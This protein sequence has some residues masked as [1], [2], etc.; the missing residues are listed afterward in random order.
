MKNSH[1]TGRDLRHSQEGRPSASIGC[2]GVKA[3]GGDSNKHSNTRQGKPAMGK[4]KQKEKQRVK[5]K[6]C[7]D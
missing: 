5:L 3:H 1:Q 2:G 4:K 6:R 7:H